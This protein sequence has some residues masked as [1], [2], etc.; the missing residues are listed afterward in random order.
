MYDST[1]IIW[2]GII[3]EWGYIKHFCTPSEVTYP[4]YTE[5]DIYKKRTI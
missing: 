2:N 3:T 1:I 4:T 5:I